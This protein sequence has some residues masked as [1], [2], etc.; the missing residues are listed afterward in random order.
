MVAQRVLVPLDFSAPSQQALNYAIELAGK[1]QASLTLLHVIQTPVLVGGPAMGVDTSLVLYLEE[2]EAEMWQTIETHVA[3][4]QAAGLAGD[5]LV[6]HGTPFQQII[7]IAA[8]RQVDLIVMGTHGHTG[9]QHFFLGSVAEK[10]VRMAP[11]PVLVTRRPT[12][13]EMP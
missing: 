1:L 10:V 11:C 2:L 8:A 7:D 12:D 6:V 13:T 9:L 4:V 3:R 5:A